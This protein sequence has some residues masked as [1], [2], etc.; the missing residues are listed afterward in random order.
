[1]LS[2]VLTQVTHKASLVARTITTHAG[3]C[4]LLRALFIS[5]ARCSLS[6]S[7]SLP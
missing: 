3:Q 6:L 5:T 2:R 4:G 1:M 7:L